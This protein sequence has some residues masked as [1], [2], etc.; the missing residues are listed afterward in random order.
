M[1]RSAP[2][3][4]NLQHAVSMFSNSD[5]SGQAETFLCLCPP[6][7]PTLTPSW[8]WIWEVESCSAI[9]HNSLLPLLEALLPGNQMFWRCAFILAFFLSAPLP[10]PPNTY[11]HIH[12]SSPGAASLKCIEDLKF[13]ITTAPPIFSVS[14]FFFFLV[15]SI[16]TWDY[17]GVWFISP[18]LSILCFFPHVP[19]PPFHLFWSIPQAI[20]QQ[21]CLSSYTCW[22]T[23][24]RGAVNLWMGAAW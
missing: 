8:N 12:S 19:F 20:D 1:P 10:H 9:L 14:L 13:H 11:I 24:L 3:K 22:L 16:C 17:H 6:R 21:A 18:H 23:G 4:E 5:K 7:C 2:Q 15:P